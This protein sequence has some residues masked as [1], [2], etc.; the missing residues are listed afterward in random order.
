MNLFEANG[1]RLAF[2]Q[3]SGTTAYP[4]NQSFIRDPMAWE[5]GLTATF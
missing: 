4:N 2:R 5:L 1:Y 3:A